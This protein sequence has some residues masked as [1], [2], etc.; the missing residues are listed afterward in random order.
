MFDVRY[1]RVRSRDKKK[2]SP[3]AALWG[4][5]DVTVRYMR[6][7]LTHGETPTETADQ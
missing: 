6:V 2:H 5:P 3:T 4:S 7:F 1:F